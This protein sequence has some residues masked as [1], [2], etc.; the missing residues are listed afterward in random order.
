MEHESIQYVADKEAEPDVKPLF[1]KLDVSKTLHFC[2]YIYSC[3]DRGYLDQ[4]KLS[5]TSGSDHR[6]AI[7]DSLACSRCWAVKQVRNLM[8]L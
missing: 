4:S 8:K 1:V 5:M 7:I 6:C 2:C 3:F